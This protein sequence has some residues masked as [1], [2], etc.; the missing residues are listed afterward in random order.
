M[1]CIGDIETAS[2]F[3]NDFTALYAWANSPITAVEVGL[4]IAAC[5]RNGDATLHGEAM[6]TNDLEATCLGVKGEPHESGENV[7]NSSYAI[8]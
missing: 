5:R 6:L 7:A 3:L 2:G 1:N 4:R 8:R